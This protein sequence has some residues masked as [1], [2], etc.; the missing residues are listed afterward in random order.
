MGS[1]TEER[2]KYYQKHQ[3][4]EKAKALAR[5]W[6]KKKER[7][8]Q[9]PLYDASSIKVLMSLKEYSELSKKPKGLVQE[10]LLEVNDLT[11]IGL[12]DI[13]QVQK[14]ELV[15]G[16][17][18]RDYYQEA[19][20]E[21]RTRARS[22]SNLSE[23]KKQEFLTYLVR[24]RAKENWKKDQESAI[25][26]QEA[27]EWEKEI[28]KELNYDSFH[29]ERGKINCD[30]E[31]CQ[32]GEKTEK[33]LLNQLAKESKEKV[34]CANCGRMVKEVNEDDICKKCAEELKEQ[35]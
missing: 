25:I 15:A 1:R 27:Q 32:L 35:F 6:Q 29:R 16:N 26:N 28:E 4:Q 33:E 21:V 9:Q 23:K 19:K 12:F 3:E 8:K 31:R 22:W 30:C 10:F 14:L 24:K 5:Y 17:L 13:S 34:E 18:V 7:K 20:K 11:T 2:R